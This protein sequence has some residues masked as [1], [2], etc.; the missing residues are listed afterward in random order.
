MRHHKLL[1]AAV[2]VFL[3]AGST[4]RMQGQD[5]AQAATAATAA[6]VAT[7]QPAQ[8]T[9]PENVP[10]PA[11]Q[12]PQ[13]NPPG[14]QS[15]QVPETTVPLRVMTNKS[16]LINTAERM[17]RVSI[18]DPSVADAVVVTP[19]QIMIHGRS[20]GE[21]TLVVWDEQDRSRSFD[22]RVDVDS[23][24]AAQE[25][26]QLMPGEII[27]VSASRN[28]LILSG[29]VVDKDSSERAA[30]IA[31]AYSKN[32]INVLTFG[33]V[34]A[35]EVLL[36][37]RFIEVDRTALVQ[38]GVNFLSTGATNTVGVSTTGQF[39]SFGNIDLKNSIGAPVTGFTTQLPNVDTL[40]LF[41]FR[42]GINMVFLFH[43]LTS[44]QL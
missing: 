7:S 30:A 18:T 23:T 39:G 11:A 3:T 2:L 29:H 43:L 24:A 27:N 25:I 35:Q 1:F 8:P 14:I 44:A 15:Q 22:L 20:P 36:E 38:L 6:P 37:V 9:A 28:A 5:A 4:L 31:T 32:V 42:P 21:V 16:I 26:K 10:A 40:N 19:N 12:Q 13:A 33:P 17:K 41:L 34:G